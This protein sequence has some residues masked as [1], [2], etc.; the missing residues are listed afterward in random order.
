MCGGSAPEAPDP[1][2]PI[3]PISIESLTANRSTRTPYGRTYLSSGGQRL[4]ETDIASALSA[5]F[6]DPENPDFSALAPLLAA[7]QVTEES[8][9]VA[10][11]RMQDQQQNFGRRQI[12][13]HYLNQFGVGFQGLPFAGGDSEGGESSGYTMGTGERPSGVPELAMLG[14]G[15][16][17]FGLPAIPQRRELDRDAFR[18]Y[19]DRR[20]PPRGY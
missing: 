15:R 2:N 13:D 4:S 16:R 3:T 10:M 18:G 7:E 17:Q 5:V 14:A 9:E 11:L 12:A 19:M 8:P 1:I 20:R 6:A